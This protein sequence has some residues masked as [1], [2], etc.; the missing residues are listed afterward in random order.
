MRV[1]M[2]DEGIHASEQDKN[3]HEEW[4]EARGTG[5]ALMTPLIKPLK[6]WHRWSG[7]PGEGR[8]VLGA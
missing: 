2:L 4:R 3:R 6:T 8:W 7:Q 5:L 1:Y